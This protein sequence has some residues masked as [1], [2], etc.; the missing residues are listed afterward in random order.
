M[1]GAAVPGPGGAEPAA[2]ESMRQ[3]VE[4]IRTRIAAT[5]DRDVELICVTKGHPASVVRSALELGLDQLGESYAQELR[6][7]ADEL[8]PVVSDAGASWHFVGRLQ[9]NKV[10]QIADLVTLWHTIDRRSLAEEVARRA[11]GAR[12]LVQVD[13]A[14]LPGRGGCAPDQVRELT[15]AVRDLGLDL[16]G[17]MGVGAPGGPEQA[18]PG[19]ALLRQLADEL[20]LPTRCM[21]MSDDLE[22][23]I[24][25]GS[26]MLR[27]GR[28]LVGERP[29]R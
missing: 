9:R 28:A 12:V 10:R 15:M 18:R 21:G 23:A 11:P 22:V 27:I 1:S 29:A 6:A 3:R 2:T 8:G 16:E 19:F 24:E 7:K 4:R 17:L 13:L 26:T 25:E 5:S 20:E 14:G